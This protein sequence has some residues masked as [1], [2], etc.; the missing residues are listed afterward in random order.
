MDTV[1]K[2]FTELQRIITPQDWQASQNETLEG[3][4]EAAIAIETQLASKQSLR[5]MRRLKP[6]LTGMEH[7]A[8]VMDIL[9]NGTPFLPWIWALIT[10]ILRVASEWVEALEQIM[11]G[12]SRI[13][14]SL[15]RFAILKTA[16]ATHH[17]FQESLAAVYDDILQFHQHAYKFVRRSGLLKIF[18]P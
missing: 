8:K 2:A 4:R 13:A 16:F 17:G 15:A 3:V 7:Y 11:D 5:N 10:L 9:C 12:Y 18:L 6:L 14:T 1:S